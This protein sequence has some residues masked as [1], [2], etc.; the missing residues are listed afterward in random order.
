[1]EKRLKPE[2]VPVISDKYSVEHFD[3]TITGEDTSA[4]AI[5]ASRLDLIKKF[6]EEFKDFS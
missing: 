6:D 5:P 4:A 3:P 2:Y 1:M